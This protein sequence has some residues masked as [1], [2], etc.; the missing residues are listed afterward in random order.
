MK[1][2]DRSK[3][4]KELKRSATFLVEQDVDN[5]LSTA[6]AANI[7]ARKMMSNG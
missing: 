4:H 2:D 6:D 7:L 1:K 5:V 3:V